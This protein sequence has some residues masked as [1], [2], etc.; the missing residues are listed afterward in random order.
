MHRR[1][2]VG[3]VGQ[4]GT[5]ARTSFIAVRDVTAR[6]TPAAAHRAA[7]DRVLAVGRPE[8]LSWREVA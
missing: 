1:P 3:A 6:L 5:E 2:V 7:Q 4:L 8:A